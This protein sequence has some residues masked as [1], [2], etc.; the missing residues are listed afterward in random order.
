MN[1]LKIEALKGPRLALVVCIG[2]VALLL[3]AGAALAADSRPG[4]DHFRLLRQHL[5]EPARS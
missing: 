2:L 3:P 4:R 5:P 1:I